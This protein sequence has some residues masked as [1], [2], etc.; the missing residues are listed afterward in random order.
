MTID[1]V[2]DFLHVEFAS[3]TTDIQKKSSRFVFEVQAIFSRRQLLFFENF[4]QLGCLPSQFGSQFA[5]SVNYSFLLSWLEQKS[6]LVSNDC[7]SFIFHPVKGCG[8]LFLL[9][10]RRQRRCIDFPKFS[11]DTSFRTPDS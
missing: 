5:Q 1:D 7:I 4:F 11:G 9:V 6:T 3:N 8:P 2:L 10:A